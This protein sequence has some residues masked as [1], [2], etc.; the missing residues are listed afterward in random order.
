MATALDLIYTPELERRRRQ[1][2][3]SRRQREELFAAAGRRNHPT[4]AD[5]QIRQRAQATAETMEAN[6]AERQRQQAEARE[7]AFKARI[8]RVYIESGGDAAG[9]EHDWPELRAEI[10][11]RETLEAAK[12]DNPRRQTDT[13]AQRALTAM[14]PS[15]TR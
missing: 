4:A 14:Y 5:G 8:Q 13:G 3:E 15:P 12:G 11:R 2:E 6:E 9:F 10:V 7:A 1:H